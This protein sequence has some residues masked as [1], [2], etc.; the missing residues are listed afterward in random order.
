MK[1]LWALCTVLTLILLCGCSG[2]EKGREPEN[3]VPVQVLGIDRMGAEYVLT[4]VGTDGTGTALMQS[5]RGGTL[6]EV[7]VALPGA[8]ERWFALTN[9]THFLLGDGVEPVEVLTFILNESGMSWRGNVWYA[10]L[11]AAVMAEQK[12]GGMA[13]LSVL[14]QTETRVV[15][16]LE[17]LSVLRMDGT[18]E[19]PALTVRDGMLEVSGVVC[20]ETNLT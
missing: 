5:A 12:D 15:T 1:R 13:R 19:L 14:Q 2:G 11:A 6:E 3:T 10:P 17:T 20:Y 7:F 4:A 16:V 9:V 8:G 18:A